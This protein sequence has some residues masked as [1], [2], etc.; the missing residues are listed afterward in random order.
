MHLV[1]M[2]EEMTKQEVRF[3]REVFVLFVGL[4][5]RFL[6]LLESAFL[7]PV[8]FLRPFPVLLSLGVRSLLPNFLLI[9]LYIIEQVISL[10]Y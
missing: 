5:L 9:H 1:V 4:V 10:Y 8:E 7:L 2:L 3:R 6:S